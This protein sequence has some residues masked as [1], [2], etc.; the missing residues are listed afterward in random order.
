MLPSVPFTRPELLNAGMSL[1]EWRQ[2]RA[3]GVIR[4]TVRDVFVDAA[5]PD[6]MDLRLACVGRRFR[7][8]QAVARS[9]A[10]WIYGLDLLDQRGDPSA[11][12]VEVVT[13]KQ[14]NRPQSGLVLAHSA[15]DLRAADVVEQNGIVLTSPLRT[16]TDMARFGRRSDAL[17]ALDWFLHKGFFTAGELK[18]SIAR[19]SRRRGVN[20]L[21]E[22]GAIAS[23]LCESVGE[24]W[25]RL[26]VIDGGLR[27]PDLQIW[28]HDSRGRPRYRLDMGYRDLLLAL[29]YDGAEAHG[30][31]AEDHDRARREWIRTQGWEVLVFVNSDVFERPEVSLRRI[32]EAIRRRTP[33]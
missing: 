14:G 11:L 20:Q 21:R 8:G 15:D 4:E 6:T 25:L 1:R 26:L 5:Q 22:L 9:T 16:A 19:W 7:P 28:V 33:R 23:P 3:D 10:A 31:D 17:V 27:L 24:S 12:P 32:N 29:E 18:D 30:P 13:L 2:L